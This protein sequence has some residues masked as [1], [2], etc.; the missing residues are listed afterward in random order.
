MANHVEE[1]VEMK[2]KKDAE[3]TETRHHDLGGTPF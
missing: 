1:G 3:K 2:Q